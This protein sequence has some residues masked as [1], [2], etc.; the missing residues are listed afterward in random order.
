MLSRSEVPLSNTPGNTLA[1]ASLGKVSVISTPLLARFEA[2][3]SQ[4]GDSPLP[5]E[6]LTC[7]KGHDM[8]DFVT[9]EEGWTCSL[10]DR[11]QKDRSRMCGCRQCDYDI[12]AQCTVKS[13]PSSSVCVKRTS[14]RQGDEIGKG[15][16]G[17]VYLA[18]DSETGHLFAAKVSRSADQTEEEKKYTDTLQRELEIC[19]GLHHTHIVACLGHEYTDGRLTIFLEYVSGG[20]LRRMLEKFGPLADTLLRK[21]TSGILEGLCFLHTRAP[22]VV[23]RDLM[24]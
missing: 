18:Q 15:A 5:P 8:T 19:K 13:A 2:Y 21:A 10:C 14:W 1:S 11:E 7:P 9:E 23:H 24:F 22:P 16:F 17:S 20:S 12:C 6:K 3:N 4:A